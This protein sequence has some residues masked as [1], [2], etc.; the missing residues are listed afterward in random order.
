[1]D[2]LATSLLTF[3]HDAHFLKVPKEELDWGSII[4]I[5]C[6]DDIRE[7]QPLEHEAGVLR[8]VITR[9]IKDNDEV[10]PKIRLFLLQD[11]H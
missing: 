3:G 4:G 11:H 8:C 9:T 10:A 7:P 6:S 5:R 1:M 2:L